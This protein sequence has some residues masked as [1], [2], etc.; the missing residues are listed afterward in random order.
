MRRVIYIG[1]ISI[2]ACLWL[3]SALATTLGSETD[4]VDFDSVGISTSWS[5]DQ[6][7]GTVTLTTK[8][9]MVITDSRTW[10]ASRGGCTEMSN[11]YPLSVTPPVA[12]YL[13]A[14]SSGLVCQPSH[15]MNI[16]F[17]VVRR[18]E[19]PFTHVHYD[20]EFLNNGRQFY[21]TIAC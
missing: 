16:N 9:Q 18:A 12:V 14:C 1:I 5:V 3:E 19:V 2:L 10:D 6:N 8:L 13:I 4:G 20:Q 21:T 17:S 11:H 15:T 7:G